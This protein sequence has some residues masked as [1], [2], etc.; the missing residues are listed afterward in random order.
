M[1]RKVIIASAKTN[2]AARTEFSGTTF[3]DLKADPIFAGIYGNGDGVEA[4]VKPGNVTLR[5]DDS[6]LPVGDFNVFLVATK[7][8]AGLDS[9]DVAYEVEEAINEVIDEIVGANLTSLRDALIGFIES[10]KKSI[11]VVDN[12]G[13]N[14]DCIELGAALAEAKSL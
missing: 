3:G 8:K 1:S 13:G 10:Y 5:G 4:I 9:S 6:V 12:C 11:P 2:A 14:A 7:N